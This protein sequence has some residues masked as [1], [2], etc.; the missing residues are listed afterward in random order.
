MN[1]G[2]SDAEFVQKVSQT[3]MKGGDEKRV[4]YVYPVNW[5]N[6]KGEKQKGNIMINAEIVMGTLFI[7]ILFSEN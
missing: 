1:V 2:Q 4:S 5:I 7:E 6:P 3:F